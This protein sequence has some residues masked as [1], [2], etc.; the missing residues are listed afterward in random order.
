M[1][2]KISLLVILLSAIFL[3]TGCKKEEAA[4]VKNVEGTLPE[5]MEKIYQDLPAD[6]TPMGLG[7]IELTT[8]NIADFVGTSDIEFKEALA[9]ESQTGSIAHSVILIRTEENADIESIKSKIKD[10]VDPRK[11][12]CVGVE[13]EDVIIKNKGDLI[14]V[15]IVEDEVGRESID[16]GFDNL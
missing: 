7:N 13:K 16:K 14:I 2:K 15:I 11:W 3:I 1:M 5:I 9:S 12:I 6:N 4:E 8:E 10:N